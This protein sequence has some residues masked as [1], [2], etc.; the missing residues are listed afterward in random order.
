M[1]FYES[2]HFLKLDGTCDLTPCPVSN[3]EILKKS[4]FEMNGKLQNVDGFIILPKEYLNPVNNGTNGVITKTKK[5]FPYI[6]MHR[7]GAI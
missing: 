6:I 5:T 1:E 7:H 4:G 2:I 3:S